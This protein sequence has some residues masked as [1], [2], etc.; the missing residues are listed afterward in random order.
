MGT[1]ATQGISDRGCG[2]VVCDRPSYLFLKS[3][4]DCLPESYLTGVSRIL[5]EIPGMAIADLDL[6]QKLKFFSS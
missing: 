1:V 5:G 2:S 6:N 3:D 4:S